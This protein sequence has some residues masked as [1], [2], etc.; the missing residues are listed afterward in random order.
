MLIER[1]T[2]ASAIA[3]AET[4]VLRDLVE[5][6][7]AR[8]GDSEMAAAASSKVDRKFL[9]RVRGKD[10]GLAGPPLASTL[11][12]LSAYLGNQDR[13]GQPLMVGN[14]KALFTPEEL[15]A[16]TQEEQAIQQKCKKPTQSERRQEL[17]KVVDLLSDD[18]VETMLR[19]AQAAIK[20][21]AMEEQPLV[22]LETAFQGSA[23]V[24]LSSLIKAN[25][26]ARFSGSASVEE[27]V[28]A[29]LSE[30]G[31]AD[32]S[33]ANAIVA[34]AKHGTMPSRET[35]LPVLGA[36]ALTLQRVDRRGRLKGGFGGDVDALL[37]ECGVID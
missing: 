24:L 27:Q 26:D 15:W 21:N 31:G 5:A 22:R 14:R 19:L 1:R 23:A 36:L 30:A 13:L 33:V 8:Y 4:G 10:G 6:L 17:H 7:I 12:A 37:K 25:L 28:L 18:L 9:R 20:G 2:E 29:L 32:V 34:I 3:N 11:E 35:V 16:L